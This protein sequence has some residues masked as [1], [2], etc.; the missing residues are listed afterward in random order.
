MVDLDVD[1]IMRIINYVDEETFA[2]CRQISKEMHERTKKYSMYCKFKKLYNESVR[3]YTEKKAKPMK[4]KKCLYAIIDVLIE[5][6]KFWRENDYF[7]FTF[8][9]E[10]YHKIDE[11]ILCPGIPFKRKKMYIDKLN[12][13]KI[14]HMTK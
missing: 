4:K 9:S 12:Q 7:T 8:R 2:K 14:Q 13:Y 10:I 1:C 5:H 3:K 11:V 6:Q